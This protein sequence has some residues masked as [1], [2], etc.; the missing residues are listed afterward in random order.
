MLEVEDI[1]DARSFW[2]NAQYQVKWTGW[3]EDQKWYYTSRFDSSLEIVEDFYDHYPN[4]PS[5]RTKNKSKQN[6]YASKAGKHLLGRPCISIKEESDDPQPIFS[7]SHIS[8]GHH[9]ICQRWVM[10]VEFYF[11]RLSQ[12]VAIYFFFFV[13]RFLFFLFTF[14]DF[15]KLPKSNWFSLRSWHSITLDADMKV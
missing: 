12:R 2:E 4:N 9:R 14:L 10:S 6:S 7:S 11:M 1:L 5:P 3:N 15:I 8:T 13:Y